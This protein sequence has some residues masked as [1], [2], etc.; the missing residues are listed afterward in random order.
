MNNYERPVFWYSG[1]FLDPQ[2]FQQ[3]DSHHH[4]QLAAAFSAACPYPWGAGRVEID[5]AALALGTLKVR[6]AELL[7][8]DASR[9]IVE[10]V[11][12]EG[13]AVIETLDLKEVWQNRREPVTIYVGLAKAAAKDNVAGVITDGTDENLPAASGRYL[14][15]EA[16][17]ILADRYALPHPSLPDSGAPV[18]TLYYYL[19]LFTQNERRSRSDLYHFPLIRL[20]DEHG[21]GPRCDP[22]WCPPL[23]NIFASPAI[24]RSAAAFENRLAALVSRLAPMRPT[25][26][27][28]SAHSALLTLLSSASATLHD[29]RFLLT[30]PNAQAY[31]LFGILSSGLSAMCGAVQCDQTDFLYDMAALSGAI[32]FNHNS[33]MES[34]ARLM[35][36]Y[37]RLFEKVLPEV[38]IELPFNVRGELLVAALNPAAVLSSLELLLMLKTHA[39]VSDLLADGRIL[40]GSPT[41]VLE[42]MTRAVPVL[43][44][45]LVNPPAGL[46]DGS[47]WVYLK[48]DVTSA[49]WKQALLEGELAIAVLTDKSKAVLSSESRVI[50]IKNREEYI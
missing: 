35:P 7:F 25:N 34:L 33:P 29:L 48:P 50:F 43:P 16:D 19:R 36:Y 17:E 31:Q 5:E 20:K 10:P 44:L 45:T 39:P 28:A 23:I 21:T 6:K 12:H 40:A 4:N 26:I 38:A 24:L 27:H 47:G 2:H 30:C 42:A 18:R 9:A 14:A 41:D 22:G 37:R 15:A 13:N 3:M 1:Q 11:R 32:R 46:P 8:P 49:A